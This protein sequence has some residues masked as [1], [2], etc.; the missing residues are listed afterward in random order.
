MISYDLERFISAHRINYD[1]AL[2][3]IRN[4]KKRSHWMWYIFPQLKGLGCSSTS[5]YYGIENLEEAKCFLKDEYL[6]AHLIEISSALLILD[7][8]DARMVM[9]KP[10]DKKL[11]SSMTL[12]SAAAP[13]EKVFLRVLEKYFNGR[14][15]YRTLGKL[16]L[17]DDDNSWNRIPNVEDTVDK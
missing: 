15:D 8:N 2:S 6:G 1:Q 5:D 17:K 10:D 12:F 11:K 7:S 3:E 4:G 13:Q 14:P 16:G 9:G